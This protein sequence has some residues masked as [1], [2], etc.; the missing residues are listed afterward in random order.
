MN[1][2]RLE[3]FVVRLFNLPEETELN[4]GQTA[5]RTFWARTGWRAE[6]L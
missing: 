2:L 6:L 3:A 5:F 4:N 1:P